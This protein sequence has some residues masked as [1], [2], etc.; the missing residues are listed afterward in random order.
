MK[1]TKASLLT[2]DIKFITV[3]ISVVRSIDNLIFLEKNN[4]KANVNIR[5]E[6][7]RGL[8]NLTKQET[9]IS[10]QNIYYSNLN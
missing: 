3:N 1:Q 10:N 7:H 5:H 9:L 6:R 8:I 2:E 4:T